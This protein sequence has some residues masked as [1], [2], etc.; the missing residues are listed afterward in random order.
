ML[1]A[2]LLSRTGDNSNYTSVKKGHF[3][4]SIKAKATLTCFILKT[5][6]KKKL[7]EVDYYYCNND[8][9][10]RLTV[11]FLCD[12]YTK[13]ESSILGINGIFHAVNNY[14]YLLCSRSAKRNPFWIIANHCYVYK[15]QAAKEKADTQ[16]ILSTVMVLHMTSVTISKFILVIPVSLPCCSTL[17][18]PYLNGYQ[19]I[20]I[21]SWLLLTYSQS[22]RRTLPRIALHSPYPCQRTVLKSK[23]RTWSCV[24]GKTGW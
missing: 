16:I 8:F 17:F 21:S 9:W 18:S 13:R 14:W 10:R 4:Y 12:K 11:L 20:Y 7:Q 3:R 15:H 22:C 6:T 23:H 1:F 24:K 2:S 5:E 19:E